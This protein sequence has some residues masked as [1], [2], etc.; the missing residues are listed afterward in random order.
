MAR[1]GQSVIWLFILCLRR[2]SKPKR[3][4]ILCSAMYYTE[5]MDQSAS[6]KVQ[7]HVTVNTKMTLQTFH[8]ECVCRCRPYPNHKSCKTPRRRYPQGSCVIFGCTVNPII[9]NASQEHCRLH[10]TA[11]SSWAGTCGL[12][13]RRGTRKCRFPHQRTCSVSFIQFHAKRQLTRLCHPRST[14]YRP[15]CRA[16]EVLHGRRARPF[17]ARPVG[18]GIGC[19]LLAAEGHGR[20]PSHAS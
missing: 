14:R 19:A 4:T 10:T 1:S 12:E 16:R 5:K 7:P 20:A 13:R 2:R 17:A 3:Y 8:R 9:P 6:D 11:T 18:A 15:C